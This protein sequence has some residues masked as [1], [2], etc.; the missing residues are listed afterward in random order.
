ML[1]YA[2]SSIANALTSY[3]THPTRVPML[4]LKPIENEIVFHMTKPSYRIR[5]VK[6][7]KINNNMEIFT[8]ICF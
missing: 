1:C 7:D 2:I 3:T 4:H 5:F 6:L 8:N